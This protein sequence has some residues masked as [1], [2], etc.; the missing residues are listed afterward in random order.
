MKVASVSRHWFILS[1]LLISLTLVACVRPL[2]D[3]DEA[4]A[5][6]DAAAAETAQ[7]DVSTPAPPA[8]TT[9][10][11]QPPEDSVGSGEEGVPE[12]GEQPT[13]EGG[14]QPPAETEQP[15]E[16]PT[17]SAEATQVTYVVKA[18]D[19]L[20]AIAQQY[21]VSVE[22]IAAANGIATTSTLEIG[23][24]LVIPVGGDGEESAPP[25]P[26]PVPPTEEQV[27]VVKPGENLFRIGLQYGYTVAELAAYNGIPN[28]H[29]IFPGQ[30]IRI[31]PSGG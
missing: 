7:P 31:P 26:E 1:L 10:S 27:H 22:S 24:T 30:E 14:E 8:A 21:S 25:P 18:G 12:S 15:S 9:E 4:A 5:T 2:Q 16:P 20:F 29:W 3:E 23:Q 6:E 19:T 17:E 28:P 13:P 11:Q